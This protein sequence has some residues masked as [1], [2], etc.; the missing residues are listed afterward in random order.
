MKK[1]ICASLLVLMTAGISFAAATGQT[2]NP[3]KPKG[4]TNSNNVDYAYQSGADTSGNVN[5]R[6]AI[7]T[8]HRS[9]DKVYGTV[10]GSGTIYYS[11]ARGPGTAL[12]ATD[13]PTLPATS[14]DSS[15]AGGAA[16]W[17]GM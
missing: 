3:D 15:V 1:L 17:V 16:G 14:T 9:G 2:L 8:K 13:N 4:F 7:S 5:D 10:S 11:T 12:V 6:Y